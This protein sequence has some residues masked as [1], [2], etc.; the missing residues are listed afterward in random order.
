M[1]HGELG[2]RCTS[3][4]KLDKTEGNGMA[5]DGISRL[6]SVTQMK[7]NNANEQAMQAAK[8]QQGLIGQQKSSHSVQRTIDDL[9]SKERTFA[10]LTRSEQQ[11]ALRELQTKLAAFRR[12]LSPPAV[13]LLDQWLQWAS[14]HR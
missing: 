4:R 3:W 8:N 1:R 9:R 6:I 13:A 7:S 11:N 12:T 5:I 2:K 10:D 14:E